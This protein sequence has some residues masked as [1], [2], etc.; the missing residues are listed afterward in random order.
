MPYTQ[1]PTSLTSTPQKSSKISPHTRLC[2]APSRPIPTSGLLDVAAIP[3]YRLPLLTNLRHDPPSASFSVTP[4]I[5][6]ATIVLISSPT[7]L[8]RPGMSCSTSSHFLM[9]LVLAPLPLRIRFWM[10][11]QMM[12][13][14]S[15][16]LLRLCP[17]CSAHCRQEDLPHRLA[18]LDPRRRTGLPC[19]P[20]RPNWRHPRGKLLQ[21]YRRR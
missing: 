11:L 2:S 10:T 18:H 21:G 3:T 15:L 8:S 13:R 4:P 20:T 5:T 6:R 7:K 12:I 14:C 16:V 17:A 9:P 19:R 1:P